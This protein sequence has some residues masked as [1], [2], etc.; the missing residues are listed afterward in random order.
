MAADESA[1]S[2]EQIEQFLLT[3]RVVGSKPSKKGI[4][5]PDRLTL[6]DGKITHDAFFETIDEHKQQQQRGTG[7]ELNFVDSYKYNIAAYRLAKMLGL[8]DLVPVVRRAYLS[9][10]NRLT[11]LD[12]AGA[13]GCGRS[14]S[15]AHTSTR[16]S[17]CECVR[18]L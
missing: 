12:G 13:D 17:V 14:Y 1:L 7:I 2:K 8:D 15:K 5:H 3:A 9:E 4:T 16:L 10:Q 18:C 6:R 11:Q